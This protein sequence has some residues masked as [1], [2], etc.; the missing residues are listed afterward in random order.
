[1]KRHTKIDKLPTVR[2]L[3]GYLSILQKLSATGEMFVSSSKLAEKMG[4]IPI[5]VRKDIELIQVSG[6]PRI[7]YPIK[8]LIERIE[9]YLGWGAS[10]DAVL[11]GAGQLGSSIL[12]N[13]ELNTLGLRIAAGFDN[14]SR[15]MKT[16]V[17]GVPI[18]DS[19]RLEELLKTMH[20]GLAI[21]CV[22]AVY[23]QNVTDILVASGVKGIWNFTSARLSVPE[24]V[25]TQKEDLTPG[26]AVLS[27]KLTRLQTSACR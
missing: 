3:P 9:N 20:I 6:T 21:L 18:Y 1:M 14:D 27:A 2:R 4:I 22:P 16:S 11:I 5:L 7:G 15:K 10:L 25:I 8:L 26:Y 12:A 17:H 19:A 13:R 24:D 23:A